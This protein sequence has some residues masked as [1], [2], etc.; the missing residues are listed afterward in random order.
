MEVNVER[1]E[2]HG[3][4]EQE[5]RGR[6]VGERAEALRVDG[7]RNRHQFINEFRHLPRAAPAHDV[8][9]NLVHEAVSQHGRMM[10]AGHHGLAHHLA[11]RRPHLLAVEEAAG[12]PPGQIHEHLESLGLGQIE[13]P[14]RRHGVGAE[15]VG[16]ERAHLR[17]VR[18]D[19]LTRGKPNPIRAG[20]K[21]A[22]SQPLGIELLVAQA[23]KLSVHPDAVG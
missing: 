7:L 17:K 15:R 4:R 12:L 5:L 23:E 22:V 8:G 19:L 18:R 13:Q 2:I 20:C 21:G 16:V 11:R 1:Q 6:K 10:R 9:R 14:A 3:R